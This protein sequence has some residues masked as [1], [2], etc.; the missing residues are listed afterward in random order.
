MGIASSVEER[1]SESIRRIEDIPT[2]MTALCK[3]EA[4]PGATIASVEVPAIGPDDVLVRVRAASICGT[5]LHIY[6]WDPWAQGRVHPPY[7][8]GHEFAGDIVAIGRAVPSE[9]LGAYIAAESHIHCGQ[10][11][12]CRHGL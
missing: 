5:D 7:V 10:C 9:L 8:F 11:F 1:A 2:Q 3:T 12:E 4:A 6:T